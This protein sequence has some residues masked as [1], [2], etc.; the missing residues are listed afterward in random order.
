MSPAEWHLQTLRVSKSP[1]PVSK[2]IPRVGGSEIPTKHPQSE[3][4]LVIW[5][6]GWAPGPL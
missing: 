3:V 1:F 5:A 2:V 4:R 6:G